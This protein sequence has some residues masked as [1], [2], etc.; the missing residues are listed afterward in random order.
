MLAIDDATDANPRSLLSILGITAATYL[1]LGWLSVNLLAIPGG[2][3]SPLFPA[4]GFAVAAMLWSGNRAWPGILLGSL[5]L[6]LG[7]AWQQGHLDYL[8][9]VT[10]CG[11]AGGAT[12]QALVA[13]RLLVRSV[14][15]AWRWLETERDI[16]RALMLAGP[17]ACLVSATTGVAVLA[18]TQSIQ[19]GDYFYTWLTWWSGDTMGVLVILPLT[20][21]TLYRNR[22]PWRERM[23]TVV[24]PMLVTLGLVA[25]SYFAFGQWERGQQTAKIQFHG[26]K[27]A[28]LL[29]QRFNAHEESI[30]ALRRLIEVTPSMSYRQFEHFTQLTLKDNPDIFA[31]SFNPYVQLAHRDAV[32]R[33]FGARNGIPGFEIKE[34]DSQKRLV[35]AADRPEYVAVGFIAP[36]KGNAPAVGY[37]INS[38]P[39]RRDAIQH[40]KIS[41]LSAVTAPIQLV[42]ENQKRVGVLVLH[43]AYKREITPRDAGQNSDLIGFAVGVIKVD[44]MVEIATRPAAVDGL[45]FSI[46]DANA[47]ADKRTIYQSAASATAG[48]AAFHW[49]TKLNIADRTWNLSVFPTTAYLQQ[50]RPWTVW[51]LSMVGLI[52]VVLLQILLLVTTGRA[53]LINNLVKER[54]RELEQ[55]DEQMRR[56]NASLEERVQQRTEELQEKAEQL[57]ITSKYKSEFLSSMSHELRT[58]LNSLLILAQMLAENPEHNLSEQQ[59]E[60][61]KIIQGAGKD[62]LELINDILDLSKIESGTVTLQLEDV[63]FASVSAQIERTFRHVAESRGL[64]FSV[65]LAPDLPESLYTDAQRLQ[66]VLKNLLSNALKFTATGQVSVRIAAVESGWSVDHDG[67]NR[68]GA[69]IGFFVTDSGIGLAADKQKII[70]EA[71]HQA[72][73][74]TARKY[75]GTGLGLSI[76]R[77]LARLLGGELHLVESA[78]GQG[79]TFALFIPLRATESGQDSTSLSATETQR[80]KE[81]PES[82]KPL[83][84]F[85]PDA[86]QS[87]PAQEGAADANPKKPSPSLSLLRTT[88]R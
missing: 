21:A 62:L 20:L 35:R 11:L 71:F 56:L 33:D 78:P 47:P 29:K 84:S 3:A 87:A 1:A 53:S 5:L 67:L 65:E 86:T 80:H 27:L 37:D 4:A 32:E 19:S 26:E 66:Q 7:I 81:N 57:A 50:E 63:S 31:L 36:L 85:T 38:E 68:A 34:R 12:L 74:G 40:A 69:V 22:S 45:V 30:A 6:N 9:L 18:L 60:Y 54:T 55:A 49:Q 43:P 70:F 13:A 88:G 77:E 2:Y 83:D 10:A 17:L 79:S 61:A 52:L 64:G 28:Q 8:S 75:G 15:N 59:I 39:I 24:L 58:P 25:G 48:D 72:D 46:E 42:Q 73:T 23:L 16:A 41:A 44:E 76:S 51:A 14:G 82:K